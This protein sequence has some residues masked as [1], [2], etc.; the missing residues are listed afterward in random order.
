VA[1]KNSNFDD[2]KNKNNKNNNNIIIIIIIIV[3]FILAKFH[4]KTKAA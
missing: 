3:I 2:F 1:K 4:I